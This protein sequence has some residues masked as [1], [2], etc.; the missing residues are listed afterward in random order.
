M[1]VVPLC[2]VLRLGPEERLRPEERWRLWRLEV[3]APTTWTRQRTAVRT[4]AQRTAPHQR[5]HTSDG[6]NAKYCSTSSENKNCFYRF[7]W[8]K[9][10]FV[11]WIAMAENRNRF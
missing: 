11:L 8:P 7:L 10:K 5:Q 6:G 1:S 9:I 3:V 2:A 4:R